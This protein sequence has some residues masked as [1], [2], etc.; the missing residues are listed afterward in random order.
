M[1][2]RSGPHY[3]F[4]SLSRPHGKCCTEFE[5]SFCRRSRFLARCERDIVFQFGLLTF[6]DKIKII[7]THTVRETHCRAALRKSIFEKNVDITCFNCHS[8]SFSQHKANKILSLYIFMINKLYI[9]LLENKICADDKT[10]QNQ[11][12]AGQNFPISHFNST[13][14]SHGEGFGILVSHLSKIPIR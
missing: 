8:K 5:A 10:G 2:L 7:V 3:T 13:K 12:T 6:A 11:S 4:L 1:F 14:K 9:N